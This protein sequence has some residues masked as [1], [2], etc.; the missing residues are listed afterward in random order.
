MPYERV[1]QVT[2]HME[3]HD[4]ARIGIIERGPKVKRKHASWSAPKRVIEMSSVDDPVIGTRRV[5]V[6]RFNRKVEVEGVKCGGYVIWF[7]NIV[8]VT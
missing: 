7:R 3:T 4:L 6:D 8:M 2:Y 5:M 1:I